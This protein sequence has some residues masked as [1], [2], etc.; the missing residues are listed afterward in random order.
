MRKYNIQTECR[1][2]ELTTAPLAL[3]VK[4]ARGGAV[5]NSTR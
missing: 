1:H 3:R 4:G 2:R 5:D